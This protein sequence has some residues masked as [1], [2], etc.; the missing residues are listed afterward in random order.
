MTLYK[1]R[2][3]SLLAG[4]QRTHSPGRVLDASLLAVL[5]CLFGT[6]AP[7][8]SQKLTNANALSPLGVKDLPK[9]TTVVCFLGY[10][11]FQRSVPLSG[12]HGVLKTLFAVPVC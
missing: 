3:H 1:R 10:T 12:S 11:L 7:D 9:I 8:R 4:A 2:E 6:D 5:V